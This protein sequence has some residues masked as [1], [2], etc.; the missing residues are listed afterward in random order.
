[1]IRNHCDYKIIDYGT[2]RIKVQN[3]IQSKEKIISKHWESIREVAD[4][5][6]YPLDIN[7]FF[8]DY[9][10]NADN[11]YNGY[12]DFLKVIPEIL[13]QLDIN[14]FMIASKRKKIPDDN[15]IRTM[16]NLLG[17][18]KLIIGNYRDWEHCPQYPL[19]FSVFDDLY[20]H[21]FQ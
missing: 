11:T 13:Y 9:I 4:K 15:Q 10:W 8:P 17:K 16:E 18:D 20:T 21:A 2:S 3:K 5:I 6:L 19:E 7:N 12:M 14:V 1:L